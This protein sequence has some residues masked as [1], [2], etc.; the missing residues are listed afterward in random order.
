MAMTDG[1]DANFY[2]FLT[3]VLVMLSGL[4]FV[5]SIFY[6]MGHDLQNHPRLNRVLPRP[7]RHRLR[8]VSR[9]F[10]EI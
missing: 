9:I 2:R 7:P 4:E 5:A 6:P 8:T 1:R 3:L 10:D